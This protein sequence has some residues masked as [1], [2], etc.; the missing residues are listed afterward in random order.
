MNDKTKTE[1]LRKI[2]ELK[3]K[4]TESDLAQKATM[5]SQLEQDLS[6]LDQKNSY[7]NEYQILWNNMNTQYLT[8]SKIQ[9][10][11]LKKIEV[12]EEEIRKL[13]VEITSSH[14]LQEDKDQLLNR[15]QG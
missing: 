3:K 9:Q 4:I 15:I 7:P 10:E 8:E 2:D 11:E 14:L 13:V 6:E 12:V 1:A 5:I